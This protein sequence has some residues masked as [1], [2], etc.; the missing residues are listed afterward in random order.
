MMISTLYEK[1]KKGDSKAI[2][3]IIMDFT[4]AYSQGYQNGSYLTTE[5]LKTEY[6]KGILDLRSDKETN[7]EE[8]NKVKAKIRK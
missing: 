7:Q 4:I 8:L 5:E 2:I 1:R 3:N 6:A